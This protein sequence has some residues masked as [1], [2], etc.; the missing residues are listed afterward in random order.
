MA[1]REW[2]DAVAT[3]IAYALEPCAESVFASPSALSSICSPML[4]A[5]DFLT[6]QS[7]AQL[8]AENL[9]LRKQLALFAP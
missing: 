5:S 2:P 6:L 3:L 1:L 9:F 4:L 7:R 8:A